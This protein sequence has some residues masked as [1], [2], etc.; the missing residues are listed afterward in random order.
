LSLLV[1]A[2]FFLF[3]FFF[4]F[5]TFTP[6]VLSMRYSIDIS[7]CTYFDLSNYV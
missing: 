4:F 2:A 7:S 1:G 6:F 3:F 5:F